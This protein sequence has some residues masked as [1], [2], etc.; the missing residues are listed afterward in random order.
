METY[1]ESVFFQDTVLTLTDSDLN[2]VVPRD[3]KIIK[4]LYYLSDSMKNTVTV[5]LN[6]ISRYAQI[7]G[8]PFYSLGVTSIKGMEET[9]TLEFDTNINVKYKDILQMLT[10]NP[11]AFDTQV[12]CSVNIRYEEGEE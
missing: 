6:L 5:N 2:F 9:F 10:H 12:S 3:G 8:L 11:S 1:I 4:V 7:N